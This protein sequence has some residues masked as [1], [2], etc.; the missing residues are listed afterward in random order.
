MEELSNEIKKLSS[1]KFNNS[2]YE[3]F[4]KIYYEKLKVAIDFSS[5]EDFINAEIK[6]IE[7]LFIQPLQATIGGDFRVVNSFD[8]SKYTKIAFDYLKQGMDLEIEKFVK[9]AQIEYQDFRKNGS[10]VV[11][12]HQE[13]EEI[14]ISVIFHLE[15]GVGFLLYQT[16][17]K[18]QLEIIQEPKQVEEERVVTTADK[19]SRELDNILEIF[20]SQSKKYD[21]TN[22]QPYPMILG[23]NG[24][25]GIDGRYLAGY[26]DVVSNV[27]LLNLQKYKHE[28]TTRFEN[29]ND[30]TLLKNQ[31][32]EI[33]K[34][35]KIIL[36]YYKTNLIRGKEIVEDYIT[37]KNVF[38]RKEGESPN[39]RNSRFEREMKFNKEHSAVVVISNLYIN[40]IYFGV[41]HDDK[42]APSK[43]FN[44]LTSNNILV[45]FCTGIIEFIN[46]IG[47]KD[48]PK[49]NNTIKAPAIAL[50]CSIVHQSGLIEIG[51]DES[52]D[53]FCKRIS[54]HFN[55]GI[56]SDRVRQNFT[57]VIDFKVNDK[58]LKK[59]RE[60]I[61][62]NINSQEKEKLETFINNKL[63]LY[64]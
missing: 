57:V 40:M 14:K 35:A 59:I 20:K 16:Y 51:F 33:N 41:S 49:A 52:R 3:K 62:P 32:V 63:K 11:L 53:N 30:N 25:D 5:K 38:K 56:T 26:Y 27:E 34:K 31:L 55:L 28:F 45:T 8:I 10:S 58:N 6:R 7:D 21:S 22:P 50:F 23:S 18:K 43:E 29:A 47:V 13:L 9:Q 46:A 64:A 61:F 48:L 4:I 24:R 60:L 15:K 19:I 36:D 42:N 37:Q 44:Y 39:E 12:T 17:L 2:S 1:L 54:E